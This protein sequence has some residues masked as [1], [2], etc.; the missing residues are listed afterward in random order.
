M[1]KSLSLADLMRTARSDPILTLQS[2]GRGPSFALDLLSLGSRIAL[3]ASFVLSVSDRLGYYGKPGE[4]GVSWGTFDS[5]LAYTAQVN[6]F[7]PAGMVPLLG[8]AATVVELVFGVT[9]ILG[10]ALRWA[11]FGAAGML[12][13][14]G[15]AM[16]ISFGIKSPLDYS[17]FAAMCCALFLGLVGSKRWS[18]DSLW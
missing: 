3:G 14:Y 7:A 2:S 15:S 11:A 12:L 9:L 8:T 13:V 5:F 17:V 18:L 4:R 6:S 1:S 10:F 16:A